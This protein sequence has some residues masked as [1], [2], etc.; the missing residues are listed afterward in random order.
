[1]RT[2]FL[3]LFAAL[4]ALGVA[5]LATPAPQHVLLVVGAPSADS[6][7]DSKDAVDALAAQAFG[8]GLAVVHRPSPSDLAAPLTERVLVLVLAEVPPA[9]LAADAEAD[10]PAVR[11]ARRDLQR[12]V[13]AG[14]GVVVLPAACQTIEGWP[15]WDRLVG[16]RHQPT[17]VWGAAAPAPAAKRSYDGGRA[18]DLGNSDPTTALEFLLEPHRI[19]GRTARL[20]DLQPELALPPDGCFGVEDLATDLNDPMEL[21][22]AANGD[23]YLIEREGRVLRLVAAEGY[24]QEVLAELAVAGGRPGGTLAQE[25][26]GLGLALDPEFAQN[27]NLFL[28]YSPPEPSVHRLARFHVTEPGDLPD[29][30]LGSA[31]LTDERVLLEVPTDRENTTCHEGGSLAFGPDG[32]LFLSTGD[33]TNPFESDGFAPIDERPER[34]W[35]DAQRSA[36]NSNDLRGA[37]LRIR[38]SDAGGYTLPAGN[39]FAPGTPNTRP[40]LYVKG[41]RNP[42][43]IAIDPATGDLYW[44]DVGPDAYGDGEAGTRGF[45]ELNRARA[46][47]FF[48][49]PYFRGGRPYRDRDFTTDELGPG[50]DEQLVNDSPNNTGLHQLPPAQDPYF[51]YS[52]AEDEH[53]PELRSGSRNAMAGPI[54]RG[55]RDE[56]AGGFPAYFDGKPLFYDWA[57]G[58]IFVCSPDPAGDLDTTNRFLAEL[59]LKHPMDMAVGPEGE[60]FVLE[61]GTDWYFN[62]DGRVRRVT[63]TGYDQAPEVTLRA[64]QSEG[65]LPL[66]VTLTA[67][68]HDPDGSD[69]DLTFTWNLGADAIPG[70][71]HPDVRSIDAVFGTAGFARPSVTVTDAAGN[72]STVALDLLVGNSRPRLGLSFDPTER[73]PRWGDS[74]PFTLTMTDEEDGQR[75][76]APG[77]PVVTARL[78]PDGVPSEAAK[79]HALLPGLAA[80]DPGARAMVEYGCTACHHTQR[81][82][83]GP[84][85]SEV[86]ARLA[87][88]GDPSA[89][90]RRLAAKILG[91]GVGEYGDVPMPTQA[92]VPLIAIERILD[93]IVKLTP[94]DPQ[95]GHFVPRVELLASEDSH[96]FHGLLHLPA[97][98]AGQEPLARGEIL[99]QAS[100]TDGGLPPSVGESL[101]GA[102]PL[103]TTERLILPAP[104]R[105]WTVTGSETSVPGIGATIVGSGARAEAANIGYYSDPSTELTW[106]LAFA[107]PG[108][109][110]VLLA[111]A[112]PESEAGATFTLTLAGS[113]F[114]ATIPATEGW[115]EYVEVRLG[116]VHVITAGPALATFS[117]TS[118]PGAAV[119]NIGMLILRRK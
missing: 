97:I 75:S 68:A 103:T 118:M 113:E 114:E 87:Q 100:F 42:F 101:A 99:L 71:A 52:Y 92:H 61:Y 31:T 1:M 24:R 77:N 38:P 83:V 111:V 105:V 5:R 74:I 53:L 43:R 15:W 95:A 44:G 29:A 89:E 57:R 6:E 86:A 47:G 63:F 107:E 96:V 108:R 49:W 94:A 4:Y 19:A 60:L 58:H 45:D 84:G 117:P 16:A 23:V 66:E 69:A 34:L 85:Y 93:A 59:E 81:R 116:E 8:K 70:K 78:Y 3:F 55:P 90:R 102:L 36:A 26:G 112:A 9:L 7:T 67:T 79:E 10:E 35:W 73:A 91:G 2:F 62:T 98:E 82:S 72:R 30:P 28:Y 12:F 110:E 17:K 109:F 65:P 25:C 22:V 106:D 64:T 51:A 88:A 33:N 80:E 46:A 54:F 41:C 76:S 14:G 21:D 18:V 32:N 56:S 20:R 104:A 11:S 40:E 37:V 48:G 27:G 119:G 115:Q 13:Q 50:F 39:L